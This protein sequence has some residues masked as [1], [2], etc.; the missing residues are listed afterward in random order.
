[1]GAVLLY[2]SFVNRGINKVS[3]NHHHDDRNGLYLPDISKTL[4]EKNGTRGGVVAAT[5]FSGGSPMAGTRLKRNRHSHMPVPAFPRPGHYSVCHCAN[6]P[7]IRLLFVL[8][9]VGKGKFP[10]IF[11]VFRSLQI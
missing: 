11:I 6:H 7:V 1:M 5:E 4:D 3:V 2:D 10:N 9:V 8:L